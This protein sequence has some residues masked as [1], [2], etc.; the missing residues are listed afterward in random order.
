MKTILCCATI[1]MLL[2][3]L[4]CDR[5]ASKPKQ[6][7][8][9]INPLKLA[10]IPSDYQMG[11]TAFSA[12]G[13]HVAVTA[14]KDGRV[15]VF[16]DSKM[17]GN[18]EA[19]RDLIF[20]G[21]LGDYAFISRKDGKESI[22]V[23]GKE[24]PSYETVGRPFFAPDGRII[25]TAK[26]N[27]KWIVAAGKHE[28]DQFE[29]PYPEPV[30]RSDGN[31]LFYIVEGGEKKCKMNACTIELKDCVSGKAYDAINKPSSNS[32]GSTL[33]YIAVK[34]AKKTV[35]TVDLSQPGLTEKEGQWYDDVSVLNV[36]DKGA[37]LAYLA[38]TKGKP[39]LIK[40]GVEMPVDNYDVAFEMAVSDTGRVLYSAMLKGKVHAYIDG[41]KIGEE[42]S[43]VNTL[44]FSPDGSNYIFTADKGDKSVLIIN[45]QEIATFDKVVTPKFS[46]D[47]SMIA[48]RA[49][50]K[51][52][53]FVVIADLQG[54]TLRELPHYEAVW[55]V[56]FSPD[57]K[58][59]GYGIRTG[60]EL[61]W[62]VEKLD[63]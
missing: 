39:V 9:T 2:T 25:Y 46:P 14:V 40:N 54:K 23:N 45:G 26:Q 31:R 16:F 22:V 38:K 62:K 63:K 47:G 15:V 27:G 60:Q 43:S 44:R 49:R 8:F 12:D 55:D 28:S 30:V 37:H 20:R 42:Y 57:G 61:W 17:S 53:R 41:K 18:Y 52:E 19:V 50:N 58:L 32:L 59:V 11:E 33:F 6:T 29:S 1:I 10:T 51:G 36:S 21:R 7:V 35:V 24:G 34:E 4:A 5:T 13:R 56:T 3:A 48:Y